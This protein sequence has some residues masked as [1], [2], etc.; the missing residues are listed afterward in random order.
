MQID[1]ENPNPGCFFPWPDNKPD[2]DGGITLRALNAETLKVVDD[3]TVV[4]RR[5]FRGNAPYDDIKVNEALREEL[6]WDYS[7]VDWTD[8]QDSEEKEIPCTKENKNILMKKQFKFA[9]FVGDCLDQLTEF[10]E[11]QEE[12]EAKNS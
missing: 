3:A 5:R 11:K 8:L 7:I 4:K 2:E 12:Q 9:I 6:M 1:T 10:K